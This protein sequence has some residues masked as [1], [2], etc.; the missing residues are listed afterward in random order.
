MVLATVNP[1]V[2]NLI[3]HLEYG[4]EVLALVLGILSMPHQ[5]QATA[6]DSIGL[7]KL[8]FWLGASQSVLRILLSCDKAAASNHSILLWLIIIESSLSILSELLE[9]YATWQ[10]VAC[11]RASG[12]Q[13][14]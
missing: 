14:H 2:T 3:L 6:P 1:T 12:E 7:S 8:R 4:A 11:S 13:H 10:A 5:G 9:I